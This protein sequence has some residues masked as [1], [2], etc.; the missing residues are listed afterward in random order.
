MNDDTNQP[1][2]HRMKFPTNLLSLCAF[3]FLSHTASATTI[4]VSIHETTTQATQLEQSVLAPQAAAVAPL[5][6]SVSYFFGQ[7]YVNQPRYVRYDIVNNGE[8]LLRFEGSI[9]YGIDF[10]ERHTCQNGI[11]ARS[12]CWVE[13]RYMP[14]HEGY[15]SGQLELRFADLNDIR[16]FL[17]GQATR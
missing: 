13:I 1:G 4:S 2:G 17:S 9:M 8:Q 15:H 10:N 12:R 16:F 14:F 3:L 5:S 6:Q 11:P 7:T